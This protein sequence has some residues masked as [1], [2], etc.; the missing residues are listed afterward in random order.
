MSASAGVLIN[1][2]PS[3]LKV[4]L[5]FVFLPA[6]VSFHCFWTKAGFPFVRKRLL[7]LI[8]IMRKVEVSSRET[9]KTGSQINSDSTRKSCLYFR[10]LPLR[11]RNYGSWE[12][13]LWSDVWWQTIFHFQ[14]NMHKSLLHLSVEVTTEHRDLLEGCPDIILLD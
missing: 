6:P 12:S 10:K 14:M 9:I 3:Q 5:L 13:L 7:K 8:K 1:W 11:S 2:P 4:F